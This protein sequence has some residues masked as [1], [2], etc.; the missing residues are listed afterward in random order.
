MLELVFVIVIIGI[1]A[2]VAIPKFAV[3]K[4]QAIESKAATTLAAVRSSLSSERQKRV[5]RGLF[6]PITSLHADGS[7]NRMFTFFS[8]T[9]DLA[10]LIPQAQRRVLEYSVVR[11]SND[12]QWDVDGTGLIYTVSFMN[13]RTCSFT[14][15]N[16]RLNLTASAGGM[17][18]NQCRQVFDN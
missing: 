11:G 10:R 12:G 18:M 6:D 7:A 15:A 16:N 5:L 9:T 4:N 8:D 2:S 1:L 3:T 14:L 17:T 13:S